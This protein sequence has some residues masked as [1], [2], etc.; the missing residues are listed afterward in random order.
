MNI[1]DEATMPALRARGDK[2]TS[3]LEFLLLENCG[4]KLQIIT[5]NERGSM[6]CVQLKDDPKK[7][8]K[9]FTDKGVLLDFREPDILRITPAPLYNN[10]ED[11]FKL[12]QIIKETL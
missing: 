8:V 7:L 12:S 1:F 11:C 2:L 4:E 9:V 6:L 3:Y 5:P 10:F